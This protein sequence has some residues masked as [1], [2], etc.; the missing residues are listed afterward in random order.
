MKGRGEREG[1]RVVGGS[2]KDEGE[3]EEEVEV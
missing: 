3:E 1:R 2:T